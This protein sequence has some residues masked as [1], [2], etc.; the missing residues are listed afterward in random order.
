MDNIDIGMPEVE[1]TI[2]DKPLVSGYMKYQIG[3]FK[4][5][6]DE[7]WFLTDKERQDLHDKHN[8]GSKAIPFN[9]MFSEKYGKNPKGPF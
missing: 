2:V 1:L 8:P 7:Y 4:I 5:D 3:N 9:P 6:R